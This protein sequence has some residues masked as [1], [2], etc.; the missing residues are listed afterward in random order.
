M[1]AL[2]ALLIVLAILAAAIGTWALMTWYSKW[3]ERTD[4]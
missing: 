1:E 4:Y 3:D 2:Q